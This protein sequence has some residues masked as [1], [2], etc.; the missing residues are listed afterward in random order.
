MNNRLNKLCE[1][2]GYHFRDITLLEAALTHRSLR[3]TNNERLEF[4][5]DSIVNFLIAEALYAHL[6]K[7]AEGELSHLRSSLVK[8]ETLAE[9][10]NEYCLGTY[11]RLGSGEI[12]SGGNA[13]TSILADAMEAVIA[14]IYLDSNMDVCKQ[15]VLHWYQSRLVNR[16]TGTSLKDP[17]T[18]LQE[19]LQSQ[20]LPLPLYQVVSIVG[21]AHAQ[22]F[23]VECAV[24]A[25]NKKATGQAKSRRRAEQD[26]AARILALIEVTDIHD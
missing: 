7:A 3:G 25:L 16:I 22:V 21:E 9:M 4:L 24:E 11:L 5:G 17:K 12:K 18:R 13:R 19:Y 26:S 15:L 20:R 14:A 1:Q 23:I 10:A 6:P 8:G 2:L